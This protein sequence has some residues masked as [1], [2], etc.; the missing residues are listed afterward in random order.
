MRGVRAV[1]KA[2]GVFKK[3]QQQLTDAITNCIDDLEELDAQAEVVRRGT[4]EI[5]EARKKAEKV[6]DALNKIIEA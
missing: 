4:F 2:L 3:I 6:L 1:S 5:N